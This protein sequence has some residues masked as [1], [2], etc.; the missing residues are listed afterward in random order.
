[1]PKLSGPLWLTEEDV[2]SHVT[3]NDAITG[4]REGLRLEAEGLASNV[5][6]AFATWDTKSSM[7]ALGSMMPERGYAGFKTWANTPQGAAAVFSL[8]SAHQGH[9][10]ALIEAGALGQMR[11][12]GIAGV[13][14]GALARA[15]AD[16][17][18]I[19]G[20]GA[21]ALM[22]VAAVAATRPLR[23]VRVHSRSADHRAAFVGKLRKLLSMEI[24]D[25]DTLEKTV[26]NAPIV[27]LIT[28]AHEPFLSADML[29]SG[30]HLN[31]AGAILPA[32]A[33]FTQDVFERAGLVVVDSI[34][35]AR[36]ASCEMIDRYGDDIADW[37]EVKTLGDLLLREVKRPANADLTVFKP[38]GMGLSDLSV[39]IIAYERALASQSGK[40]LPAGALSPPRW[41]AMNAPP[42]ANSNSL[43]AD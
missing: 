31:A 26:A 9:L 38:M 1:M 30:T 18:A 11:T 7:H 3:L 20:T 19:V 16:E 40:T 43:P 4:L 34:E 25:C 37:G 41:E 32:N 14:T 28:R 2:R 23:R 6:K 24:L 8:F 35:N 5:D 39:A 42:P 36:K 13:A 17:M 12:A 27:T 33:E 10:L 22:Q 29:A 21:Q 15:D